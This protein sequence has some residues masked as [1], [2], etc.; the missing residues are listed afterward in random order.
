MPTNEAN[1]SIKEKYASFVQKFPLFQLLQ[2]WLRPDS[3]IPGLSNYLLSF[4]VFSGMV[5]ET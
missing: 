2:D 4:K 3:R 5:Q 1:N